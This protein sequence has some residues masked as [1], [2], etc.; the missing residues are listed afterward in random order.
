[1]RKIKFRC[2]A[3]FNALLV[4]VVA[5]LVSSCASSKKSQGMKTVNEIADSMHINKPT[6]NPVLY[7]PPTN[8][9]KI[10]SSKVKDIRVLYGVRPTTIK[11]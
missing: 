7:G 8:F 3:L 11:K 6:P 10:D 5:L 9:Q 1:M 4:P 2:L